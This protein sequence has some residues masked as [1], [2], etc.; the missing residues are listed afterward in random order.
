[1]IELNDINNFTDLPNHI[2]SPI[3]NII[4]GINFIN[5]KIFYY[6]KKNEL[7]EV[8]FEENIMIRFF[9]FYKLKWN[10]ETI[11]ISESTTKINCFLNCSSLIIFSY[12]PK[13][14][15]ILINLDDFISQTLFFELYSN[16]ILTFLQENTLFIL[17][18]KTEEKNYLSSF[19]LTNFEINHLLTQNK[20][21]YIEEINNCYLFKDYLL[22]ITNKII[23]FDLN[24]LYFEP[25][26]DIFQIDNKYE[27]NF[28]FYRNNNILIFLKTLDLSYEGIILLF[29]YFISNINLYISIFSINFSSPITNFIYNN[30][31]NSIFFQQIQNK[32]IYNIIYF[33]K[34]FKPN[35]PTII[36]QNYNTTS[37]K[38]SKFN[39]FDPIENVYLIIFYRGEI[40]KKIKIINYL[41]ENIIS[42]N[43]DSNLFLES[44]I[45]VENQIGGIYSESTCFSTLVIEKKY[46]TE[47]NIKVEK[48]NQITLSWNL[49]DDEFDIDGFIIQGSFNNFDFIDIFNITNPNI[50][51]LIIKLNNPYT[52]L[53]IL[54]YNS[55]SRNKPSE[56]IKIPQKIKNDGFIR[57]IWSKDQIK[58]LDK[59]FQINSRPNAHDREIISK[60]IDAPFKSVTY[61]FQNQRAKQ[62]KEFDC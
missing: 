21:E 45:Y 40:L 9:N 44:K 8:T 41:I 11:N 59:E 37:F 49:I 7:I 17:Q 16:P 53:R 35:N 12:S 33:E 31:F 4:T 43:L 34:P 19:N 56:H 52:Q 5:S 29:K 22:I 15:I 58:E 30:N 47:F 20:F 36:S 14:F 42:V 38:I 1:M 2:V 57:Y 60:K 61:W 10:S 24:K 32:F 26:S 50:N 13:I 23:I 55:R 62:T 48:I 51:S 27:S 25:I 6:E 18:E 39:L 54:T 3:K 28:I 46:I